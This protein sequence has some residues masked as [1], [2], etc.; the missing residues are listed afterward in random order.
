[1]LQCFILTWNHVGNETDSTDPET[2]EQGKAL[3][4]EKATQVYAGNPL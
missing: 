3:R 1:M 4:S 2:S